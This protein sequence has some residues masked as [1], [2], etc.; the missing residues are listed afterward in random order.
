MHSH[1][2]AARRSAPWLLLIALVVFGVLAVLI[3]APAED[4]G[5]W[6]WSML[7]PA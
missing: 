4:V 6:R 7:R 2:S 3:G 5:S 1:L